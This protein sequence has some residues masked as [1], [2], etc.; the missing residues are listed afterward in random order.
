MIKLDKLV[1]Q[2]IMCFLT[3]T[4]REGVLICTP[5]ILF[6]LRRTSPQN[7]WICLSYLILSK[8][9]ENTNH[10]F[11]NL[12]KYLHGITF[13]LTNYWCLTSL[14]TQDASRDIESLW[15]SI[16]L[17]PLFSSF[18]TIVF[19]LTLSGSLFQINLKLSISFLYFVLEQHKH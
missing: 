1:T 3:S 4:K 13:Q 15:I 12:A 2:Y 8:F 9:C 19:R 6:Q 17:R 14:L 11:P 5:P 16:I 18:H 7:L 10:S